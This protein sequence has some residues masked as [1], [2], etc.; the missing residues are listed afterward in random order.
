MT[1]VTKT[2]RERRT[3]ATVE[4]AVLGS[5]AAFVL[6]GVLGAARASWITDDAYISFRYARNLVDGLGLVFNA[7]ERV[8]GY[9]NLLWTLWCAGAIRLGIDPRPWSLFWGIAAFGA[10][11]A[12]LALNHSALRR[13]LRISAFS[14]PLA[15]AIAALH[16]EWVLYATGG[17]E[18]AWFTLLALVGFVLLA[19]TGECSGRRAV[20]AGVVFAL[21]SLTRPDGV[22]FAF[23][24]GLFVIWD[25]ATSHRSWP[26][27]AARYAAGFVTLWLPVTLW[28]VGY[29]G[30]FFP[31][32]YYAKS[33][34]LSW[35]SQG[36]I[37]VR[38]FFFK[39]WILLPALPLAWFAVAR[40]KQTAA[41]HGQRLLL[42]Q[43]LLASVFVLGYTAY[44]IKVG[45]DFMFGRF[46]V[47]TVP[48]LALLLDL[49]LIRLAIRRPWLQIGA[50]AGVLLALTTGPAP[51]RGM[52]VVH[53]IADEPSH[54]GAEYVEQIDRGAPI[55]ERY[56]RGLD[57]GVAF[58]GSEARL[59][60]EADVPRALECETGLTDRTIARQT[61]PE[62]GRVGHEKHATLEYVVRERK[63][64][65]AF[66]PYT[67]E[68]IGARGR[69]PFR[70]ILFDGGLRGF[71]LHWD[72]DVM[73]ELKRRGARF[74][75]FPTDLD[76]VIAGLDR[77]EPEAIAQIFEG[78]KLFYF[79]HVDDPRRRAAFETRLRNVD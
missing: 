33:A 42:R 54:Y 34:Y 27:A 2:I 9:T 40:W 57:V 13:A 61:L 26:G 11:I 16:G 73:R 66:K 62:R 8:E 23:L 45:G 37:Y 31:N 75:D 67:L 48:F 17:L 25:A 36:W 30:D 41:E 72:P 78:A 60:F 4:R 24:G 7:G 38:L 51:V 19:G 49:S 3:T 47:P 65:L 46:L 59:M 52:T 10:S 79:D 58:T 20:A 12:L 29:Y 43:T 35:I 56:L 14:L 28:R 1:N 74:E 22:I 39:Y 77:L 68:V 44:V 63:A 64:H 76:R 21:A 6:I 32:T 50:G 5:G 70:P 69:L 55:I 15:A 71:L 18:T 53:G